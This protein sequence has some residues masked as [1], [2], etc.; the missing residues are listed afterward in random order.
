[1]NKQE[2]II[3]ICKFKK[4]LQDLIQ[5]QQEIIKEIEKFKEI[6]YKTKQIFKK[7]K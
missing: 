7:I 3:I 5:Y 4:D 6:I 2:K 1:M